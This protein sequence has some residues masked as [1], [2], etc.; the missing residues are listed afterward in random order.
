MA[1]RRILLVVHP[2]SDIALQATQTTCR[3]LRDAGVEPVFTAD[4][5]QHLSDAGFAPGVCQ[6]LGRDCSLDGL[7]VVM[8]LGGDGTIL[9]AAEIVRPSTVPILGV[10]LGHV[11]FL[12]EAERDDLVS[13]VDRVVSGQYEVEERLALE[14]EISAAGRII[15]HDWALN[16]ATVEKARGD[17]M[18]NIVCAIGGTPLSSYACDGIVLSTPTG[19]T[20]YNFSAGGPVVWPTV[21][22]LLCVPLNA[23]A[24]FAKPMVID[25]ASEIAIQ[26]SEESDGADVWC[27]G[28]RMTHIPSGARV[29]GRRSRRPVRLARLNQAT[30][31][32]RLVHKF[33]LPTS[34]WRDAREP[35]HHA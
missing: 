19:S 8:V 21:E 24:L 22:A 16:D 3:L 29:V 31:V 7:E 20:A 11:G 30:F 26:V 2:R 10:N 34:G 23:H 28:R 6:I 27:D 25:P 14:I 35:R 12:A 18:I 15:A 4:G 17:K 5:W 32:S 33:D 9:Q 13:T 1:K